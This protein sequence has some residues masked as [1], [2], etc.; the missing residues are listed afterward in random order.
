MKP[1]RRLGLHTPIEE[2]YCTLLFLEWRR[3]RRPLFQIA[4]L[5]QTGVSEHSAIPAI[6]ELQ[7]VSKAF[8]N[9]VPSSDV[10]GGDPTATHTRITQPIGCDAKSFGTNVVC[11]D[12]MPS[13]HR[14]A[15]EPGRAPHLLR[16]GHT[17]VGNL[18]AATTV[19]Y[20]S[21]R[22]VLKSNKQALQDVR[23][24]LHRTQATK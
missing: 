5:R 12:A 3:C 22:K 15:H 14:I 8:A 19:L 13:R 7:D 1:S 2:L 16:R 21:V 9:I 4:S 10:G 24:A 17:K 20:Q 6:P 11:A 23:K 18:A